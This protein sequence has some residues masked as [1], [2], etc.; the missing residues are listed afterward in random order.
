MSNQFGGYKI[1]K[2]VLHPVPGTDKIVLNLPL[3]TKIFS[4]KEQFDEIVVYAEHYENTD[5]DCKVR[6]TFRVVGTGHIYK[7]D[8]TLYKFF[9]TVKLYEGKL[10]FH[11]F[12]RTTW[13][14]MDEPEDT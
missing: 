11:V 8:R 2:Y 3:H 13:Q 7:F 12:I 5:D 14:T 1:F 6:Y 10:M 9:D 4:V